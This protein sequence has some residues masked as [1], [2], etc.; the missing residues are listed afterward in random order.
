[1]LNKSR[2]PNGVGKLSALVGDYTNPILKPWAA[3]V[4][5]KDGEI[6]LSGVPYPNPI[7]Q[8]WPWVY[9]HIFEH[10]NADAPTA[11]PNHNSVC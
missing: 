7:N 9:P 6:S 11:P 10:W 4:V 2:L 1:V 8:C 5:K 3:E